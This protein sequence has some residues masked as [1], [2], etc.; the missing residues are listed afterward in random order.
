MKLKT[1]KLNKK[2]KEQDEKI[3]YTNKQKDILEKNNSLDIIE[4]NNENNI[5]YCFLIIIYVI[6]IYKKLI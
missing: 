5:F 2:D 6:K 3:Y 4:D 1:N